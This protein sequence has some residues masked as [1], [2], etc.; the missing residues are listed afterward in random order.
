MH[1]IETIQ[2]QCILKRYL[3]GPL[4]GKLRLVDVSLG[5]KTL[6]R[7]NGA[8]ENHSVITTD[9]LLVSGL[10]RLRSTAQVKEYMFST[11]QDPSIDSRAHLKAA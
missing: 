3:L 6:H 2:R 4:G 1:G 8:L 11:I 5:R 10:E 7:L 9:E